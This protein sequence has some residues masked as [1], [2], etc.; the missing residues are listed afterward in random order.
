[1]WQLSHLVQPSWRWSCRACGKIV[2]SKS[3]E[4]SKTKLRR[5]LFKGSNGSSVQFFY[6]NPSSNI[7]HLYTQAKF[8]IHLFQAIIVAFSFSLSCLYAILW[9]FS[10]KNH[11]RI[12]QDFTESYDLHAHALTFWPFW[13]DQSSRVYPSCF[14]LSYR[15]LVKRRFG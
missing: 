3:T 14:H 12:L 1:M 9:K 5:R 13:Y 6:S 11:L 8:L 2:L 7:R 4:Q 15:Q 10:M